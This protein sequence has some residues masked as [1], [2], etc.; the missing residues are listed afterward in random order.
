MISSR[1]DWEDH[2]PDCPAP[3][4]EDAESWPSLPEGPGINRANIFIK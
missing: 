1:Q 4:G 2:L 3:A